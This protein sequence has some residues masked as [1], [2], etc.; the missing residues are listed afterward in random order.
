MRLGVA[1]HLGWAIVVVASADHDVVDRRRIELSSLACS[2]MLVDHGI[3]GI[4]DAAAAA[5]RWWRAGVAARA[6]APRSTNSRWVFA[7]P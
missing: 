3:D 1:D 2:R 5:L 7:G 4:D 6:T